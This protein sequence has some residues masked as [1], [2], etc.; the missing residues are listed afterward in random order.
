M[1]IGEGPRDT[2]VGL[3]WGRQ[4]VR[5]AHV[6]VRIF[7]P[8]FTACGLSI[9]DGTMEAMRLFQLKVFN[10]PLLDR[11]CAAKSLRPRQNYYYVWWL[12]RHVYR[13]VVG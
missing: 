3:S 2:G 13:I 7:S 11:P 1:T 9:N 12:S 10:A 5:V 8:F 4:C 6:G